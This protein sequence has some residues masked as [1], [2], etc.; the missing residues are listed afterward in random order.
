MKRE[1]IKLNDDETLE[2]AI[3]KFI[4]YDFITIPVVDEQEQF[5]GIVIINDII[6]EVF[7]EQFKKKF[8]RAV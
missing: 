1:V 4:K 6:E 2:S 8:K 5:Q 3:T 7:S